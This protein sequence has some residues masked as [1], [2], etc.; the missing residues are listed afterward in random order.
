M[1]DNN[2]VLVMLSW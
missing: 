2:S 1:L